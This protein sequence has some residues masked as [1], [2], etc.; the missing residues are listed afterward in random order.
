[1]RLANILRRLGRGGRPAQGSDAEQTRGP[2]TERDRWLLR[3]TGYCWRYRRSFLLA[4]TGA[5]AGHRC[6]RRSSRCLQRSIVDN[7]ILT[8]KDSIWPLAIALLVVAAGDFGATFLRRY[9]G[10]RLSLDVQHDLRT[11]MF[12]ALSRLDGARQDELAHRADRQPVDLRPQHGPGRCCR[13]LPI[14]AGQRCCC[15]CCRS[16]SWL[17]LSPLLTLVALAVGP[18]AVVH[19]AGLAAQAVPGQLGRAAA[20]R[21]GG[22][23]RGRAPSTGV[24]VV[25][26]F[27]QEE[28]EIERLEGASTALYA[29]AGPRWP[30]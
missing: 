13:M 27:G 16:S 25:K 1:M 14:A 20:G 12:G 24:R 23:G 4:L 17:F 19:R 10:G 8:H 22:R 29:V 6:P 3:L 28:Q 26:G 9:F 5:A 2:K 30:G 18:A 21:R 11:E 15:S 7:V